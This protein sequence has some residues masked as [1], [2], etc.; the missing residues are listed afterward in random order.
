MEKEAEQKNWVVNTLKMINNLYINKYI[1]VYK[2][3][4]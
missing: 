4:I 3:V 2:A 1:Y